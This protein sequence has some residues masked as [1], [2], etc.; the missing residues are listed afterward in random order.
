MMNMQP[1]RDI[2]NAADR[3][4][5]RVDA[6]PRQFK[7]M[8]PTRTGDNE[9]AKAAKAELRIVKSKFVQFA[10]TGSD[11][12]TLPSTLSIFPSIRIVSSTMYFLASGVRSDPALPPMAAAA[13][14]GLIAAQSA[15]KIDPCGKIYPGGR[16]TNPAIF[17]RERVDRSAPSK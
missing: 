13:A 6:D 7:L 10:R 8:Q 11:P 9:F 1:F 4:T 5:T 12:F 14:C 3:S 2:L 15:D 17:A 16:R